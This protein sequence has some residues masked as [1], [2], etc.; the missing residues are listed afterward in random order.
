MPQGMWKQCKV[1]GCPG[2]TRSK[3]CDKHTHLEE[4]DKQAAQEY[5]NKN[6]RNADSQKFYES[7]AWRYLRKLKLQRNPMCETCYA[8][9]KITLAKMVDHIIEIRDGGAVLDIENLSSICHACHNKKT[10]KEKEKRN[11]KP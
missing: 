5:Y 2:L 10:A 9:G 1:P 3:Y 7:T 6:I 4:R 8:E 11:D